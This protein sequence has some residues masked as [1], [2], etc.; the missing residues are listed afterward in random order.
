V[1]W[2]TEDGHED[3]VVGD[4][5]GASSDEVDG[6]KDVTRVDQCVTRGR[7]RRLEL[8]R[9]RSQTTYAHTHRHTHTQTMSQT[10]LITLATSRLLTASMLML[11]VADNAQ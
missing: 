2:R 7:V 6:V 10:Q 1:Q 5:N 9:Q 8:E 4:L 11:S 3:V